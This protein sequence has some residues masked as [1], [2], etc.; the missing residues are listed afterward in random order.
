MEIINCKVIS[1]NIKDEQ[2]SKSVQN[3]GHQKDTVGEK[4]RYIK[5]RE[6][7][8]FF[9]NSFNNDNFNIE[10]FNAITPNIFTL[11]DGNINYKNKKLPYAEN[12]IFYMANTLSHYEI[13]N[14]DEDTL[15]LEDDVLF[16]NDLFNNLFTIITEFKSIQSIGKILYLQIS[17][18][19]LKDADEKNFTSQKVSDNIGKYNIGDISGTS[20]YYITKEC[21]K[22]ILNNIKP[23][24]ACDRY[25]E[26][27]VKEGLIEYY[28][29][30][31]KDRMF[32]LD[33]NTMWL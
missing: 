19:W 4:L 3:F 13:W 24:I 12:S 10:Y 11:E 30:L 26:L 1:V 5:R 31:S 2:D 25:L 27:F 8:D 32:K 14:I 6:K 17:T 33:T 16:D 28:I 20:A 22:I 21:K 15:V 7:I 9:L 18:P 23:F 29:P